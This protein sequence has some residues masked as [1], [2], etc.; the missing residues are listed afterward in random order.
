MEQVVAKIAVMTEEITMLKNELIGVKSSHATLHQQAVEKNVMDAGRHAEAAEKIQRLEAGIERIKEE[1]PAIGGGS[2]R[3]PLIEPKQVQVEVYAGS[4]TDS[5]SKFLEWGERVKDRVGLQNPEA[6]EAMEAAEK[7]VEPITEDRS[8]T[9]G[10][11][12]GASRELHGFLKDRTSSTAAS[13][14]RNN[15]SGLGLES[16]RLLCK[17][18]NPKTLLGTMTAQE[19]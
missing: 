15:R 16:W 5:R 1:A 10:M 18:F 9:L 4:M 7:E 19:L 2:S 11:T 14:V 17:Q 3:K 12:V 8:R 6:V 13:L